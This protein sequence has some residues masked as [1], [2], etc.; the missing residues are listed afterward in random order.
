LDR[1]IMLALVVI[2]LLGL[3]EGSQGITV[4]LAPYNTSAVVGG[5]ATLACLVTNQGSDKVKWYVPGN[6]NALTVDDVLTTS[7]DHY[8]VV[9]QYNLSLANVSLNDQGQYR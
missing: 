7:G 6:E 8:S 5:N 1:L 4:T 9:G 2:G 3:L